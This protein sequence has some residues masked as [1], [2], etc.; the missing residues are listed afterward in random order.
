V[1]KSFVIWPAFAIEMKV[2]QIFDQTPGPKAG[3]RLR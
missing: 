2:D 3:T 1:L